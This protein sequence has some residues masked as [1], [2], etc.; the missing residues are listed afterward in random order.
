MLLDHYVG[1]QQ[2]HTNEIA[3]QD[4]KPS[5]ILAFQKDYKISDLGN[6]SDKNKEFENDKYQIPGD[7]NYCPIEQIYDYHCTN[8][9][10]EKIAADMYLFGSLFFFFFTGFSASQ[11]IIKKSEILKISLTE[12]FDNDIAEWERVYTEVLSDFKRTIQSIISDDKLIEEIFI[13]VRNLC[14]PDP[15]KRG[16]YQN[17]AEKF[18]KYGLDRVISRLDYIAKKAEMKLI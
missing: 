16:H 14:H 7:P 18:N 2:L 12:N 5:N 9:F 15:R 4:L 3:H 10:N 13:L 1:L 17:V 6:S 8:D 11:V